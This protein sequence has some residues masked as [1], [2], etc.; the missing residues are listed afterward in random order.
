MSDFGRLAQGLS[1]VTQQESS[2]FNY[3]AQNIDGKIE[4]PTATTDDTSV[5]R[6]LSTSVRSLLTGSAEA[7][8]QPV[9]SI[10]SLNTTTITYFAVSAGIGVV[11]ISLSFLFLPM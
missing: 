1:F 11:L 4:Q 2:I 7:E 10:W 6:S 5:F 3:Q 9:T 8:Q